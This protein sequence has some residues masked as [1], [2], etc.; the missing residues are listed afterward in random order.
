MAKVNISAGKL[1]AF[2]IFIVVSVIIYYKKVKV[3]EGSTRNLQL[4]KLVLG[5]IVFI[6]LIKSLSSIQSISGKVIIIAVLA[7]AINFYNLN[8]SVSKCDYPDLYKFNLLG[9]SSIIIIIVILI[10]WYSLDTDIFSFLYTDEDT[11]TTTV[12]DL[13]DTITLYGT[14]IGKDCPD[15]NNSDYKDINT[16][17]GKKWSELSKEEQHDCSARSSEV[18]ERKDIKAKIYA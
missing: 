15:M 13:F 2:I 1:V 10:I 9:R 4:L 17:A 12:T 7:L 16:S 6:G 5:M 8:H 11:S 3:S 18:S 14:D